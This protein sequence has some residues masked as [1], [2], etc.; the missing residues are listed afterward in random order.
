MTEPQDPTAELGEPTDVSVDPDQ[1]QDDPPDG[2]TPTS[3]AAR[4]ED[5]DA[6]GGTGGLDAGGAG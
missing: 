3:S 2:E 5:G 4:Y 1:V 6:K